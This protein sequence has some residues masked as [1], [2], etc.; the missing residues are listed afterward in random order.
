MNRTLTTILSILVGFAMTRCVSYQYATLSSNMDVNEAREFI[1]ENDTLQIKY[2]FEGSNSPVHLTFFNKSEQALFIDWR[3]SA[4][5]FDDQSYTYWRDSYDIQ[6]TGEVNSRVNYFNGISTSSVAISGN[7]ERAE[8]I[9]FIPPKSPK[10]IQILSINNNYVELKDKSER[11]GLKIK[12]GMINADRFNF[13]RENSPIYFRSILTLSLNPDFKSEFISENEFWVSEIIQSDTGPRSIHHKGGNKIIG[14]KETGAGATVG[15]L[16][17]LG[18]LIVAIS[19]AP[20]GAG[21]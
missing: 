10:K 13:T 3:R 8:T 18:L 6:A 11:I 9:T 21:L 7:A 5:V 17:L 19:A 4:L 1:F 12:E 16:G 2:S 20:A 14:R 15:V